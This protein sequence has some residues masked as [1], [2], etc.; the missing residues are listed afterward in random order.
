MSIQSILN[1]GHVPDNAPTDVLEEFCQEAGQQL[2][3]LRESNLKDTAYVASFIVH[4]EQT[5]Q[6]AQ[7]IIN[8]RRGLDGMTP[9]YP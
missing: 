5:I 7:E 2:Q 9:I 1:S 8:S 6:Q 3:L 4:V